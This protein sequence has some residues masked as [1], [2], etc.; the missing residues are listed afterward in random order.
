[1]TAVPET[2]QPEAKAKDPK[3]PAS[4]NKL[5][6]IAEP[7][8]DHASNEQKEIATPS[9][10]AEVPGEEKEAESEGE[11]RIT[12]MIDA[13]KD[14]GTERMEA[15]DESLQNSESKHLEDVSKNRAASGGHGIS[16]LSKNEKDKENAESKLGH[17]ENA[18]EEKKTEKVAEVNAKQ[19]NE[20][21]E[22]TTPEAK[23]EDAQV[24]LKNSINASLPKKV[25]DVD[26]FK[27]N[28][29]ASNIG[30]KVK[31]TIEGKTK[32]ISGTF[33]KLDHTDPPADTKTAIP[34]KEIEKA[35]PTDSLNVGKNLVPPVDEKTIDLKSY[36]DE[37]ENLL[38]REGIKEEH[39]NLVDSGDL[40]EART[41]K[42]DME[43]KS[44]EDPN[45]IRKEEK[46]IHGETEKELSKNEADKKKEM[47]THRTG[48]LGGARTDQKDTK[49]AFEKKKEEVTNHI[50][51]IYESTNKKVLEKL[52]N[53]KTDSMAAFDREEK[54][55]S[56]AFEENVGSRMKKFKD[57]RYDGLT[58]KATKAYDWLMGIDDL[59][60]VKKIFDT[61]KADYIK[62]IDTAISTI[63]SDSQ[64]VIDECKSLIA[65]AK[66]EIDV[67][68]KG[69]SPDL[70]KI[71]ED[72]QKDIQK[73]LDEL[74]EKVNKAAAE[75]KEALAKKRAEAIAKMEA[76]I[77]KMKEEMSGML[78]KIG[79][80][81]LDAALKFFKWALEAAGHSADEIMGVINKGKAAITAI[82]SDP[83][84]FIK[85][86]ASAVGN[87][88]KNFGSNIMKHLGDGFMSWLTGQMST[89][90]IQLPE[91]FDI[92]GVV[93]VA[94]QVLGL[95]WGNLR[96]KLSNK[97]GEDKVSMVEKG[98]ES[99]LEIITE[100]KEKGP[101]ALYD[102]MADQA[103]TIKTQVIEGAKE[104]AITS[105]IKTGLIKLASMLNPA[106][107]I[108]QAILAIYNGVMFFINN[109]PRIVEF[110]NSIFNSIS[111]IANGAISAASGFVEKSLA[112]TI[113]LILDFIAQQLNL[114]GIADKITKVIHKI[115]KPIDNVI[116]KVLNFIESKIKKLWGKV[117]GK[118]KKKNS[119]EE[120]KKELDKEEEAP[121]KYIKTFTMGGESHKITV[122]PSAGHLA[123]WMDS[124]NGGKIEGKFES[125][126]QTLKRYKEAVKELGSPVISA[127]FDELEEMIQELM[128]SGITNWTHQLDG[129]KTSKEREPILNDPNLKSEVDGIVQ[130]LTSWGNEHHIGD[131]SP[132]GV[133]EAVKK[134]AE[135]IWRQKQEEVQLAL[136]EFVTMIQALDPNAKLKYRGSTARGKKSN[137]KGG[138]PFDPSDFDVDGFIESDKL[139]EEAKAKGVLIYDTKV[140]IREL[141]NSALVNI[142]TL[143]RQK[144]ASITGIRKE[145]DGSVDFYLL[146]RT[147]QATKDLFKPN[148]LH[149]KEVQVEIKGPDEKE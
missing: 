90:P 116:D 1:L 97:V 104:W 95:T 137:V 5:T 15:K 53:L 98:A 43:T 113:P 135:K 10:L 29:I 89:L 34:F 21:S 18:V 109:W 12:D 68:V 147:S 145:S 67:Y 122:K 111:S 101:I 126:K 120:D 81:L 14:G 71:G 23:K 74:D 94:L 52:A 133:E 124:K 61:E 121:D 26:N 102:M 143:A 9:D 38:K 112:S 60:E 28:K 36:V 117:S 35:L 33:E 47:E 130:F 2:P 118:D 88:I 57:E 30:E 115:R 75:L 82:V 108:V 144:L 148:D 139:I 50:N 62:R 48:M 114:S 39:L 99:G 110:V 8:H 72:A 19:V 66:K 55:A 54:S 79:D 129:V 27:D 45:A 142:E 80:L 78:S 134:G 4:K 132:E 73:K 59:P 41:M 37:S 128:K 42:E 93:S 149:D 65:G 140:A 17:T 49:S 20:V 146:V 106:G 100:V 32:E 107:A 127:E 7:K 31:N 76:R 11:T 138:L 85:N 87:G 3:N 63:I 96:A 141:R 136:Q 125:A 46:Q 103:E 40:F 13:S 6:E 123:A 92:K 91:R 56:T 22:V 70:K 105:L 16:K 83:I 131:L 86:L 51:Q 24:T 84:Q 58:G 119:K 69:L 77:E 44:S 64:K 25:E